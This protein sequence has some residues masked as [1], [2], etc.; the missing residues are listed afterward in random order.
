M[1]VTRHWRPTLAFVL[2]GALASTLAL[3]FAGLVTLRYLGPEIGF[4]NAALILGALI[5][6]LTAALGWL[7]A[8]LLLRP[9]AALERYSVEQRAGG[10]GQVDPP[11]HFGTHELHRT[12][13]AVIEMADTLR[14]REATIRSFTDHVTHE[15]KTPVSAIRAA[16]ELL[17]DG[18]GLGQADRR[19][20]GQID[21]ARVQIEAQL[22]ALRSMARSR[23]TRYLGQVTL[24]A[25]MARLPANHPDLVLTV[26]GG[27]VPVPLSAD[28]LLV[29][30]GQ[31]LRNASE[32][33]ATRVDLAVL[34]EA[35]CIALYVVDDGRGVSPGNAPRLFDPFFTTR[36]DAGGTGMGLTIVKGILAAHRGAICHVPDRNGARFRL[37]FPTDVAGP[38]PP[39]GTA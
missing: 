2:G 31:L 19:L 24:D 7:L 37:S 8:R 6:A 22:E 12:A 29:V 11:R 38:V 4:K 35:D 16:V 25:L 1:R 21:G 36:R 23:E 3:S 33:G 9:I 17:E 5:V 15:L 14:N 32:S 28:G 27:Q 13:A 20:L 18:G 34:A 26:T 30:L 39:S 10:G